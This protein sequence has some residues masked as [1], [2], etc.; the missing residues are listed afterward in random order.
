MLNRKEE[1]ILELCVNFM[2]KNKKIKLR[3][4]KKQD[5]IGIVKDK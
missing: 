1:R 5:F 3:N 4:E 2:K